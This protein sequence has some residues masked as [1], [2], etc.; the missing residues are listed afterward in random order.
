[1]QKV[2]VIGAGLSGVV[3]ARHLGSRADVTVFEKS[4][5]P[6]GR[7]STRRNAGFEFD[8]GAQFFTARDPRF[9]LFL[10]PYLRSGLV[11]DWSPRLLT[12]SRDAKPYKRDWF[13]PHYVAVPGMNALV[14]ELAKDVTV[15]VGEEI[16]QT[17]FHD[18]LWYP[19]GGSGEV[20]GPF[21]W[22]VSTCPVEQTR[23]LLPEDFQQ[24]TESVKLQGCFALMLGF[25]RQ[26]KTN[27]QA[28]VFK[29]SCLDWAAWN[30]SKPGR[31]G[32][33]SLTVLSDNAWAEEHLED[34][35]EVVQ[36]RMLEE[37]LEVAG[38]AVGDAAVQLHR[39][40]YAN[41]S[42]PLGESFLIDPER[43]VAACGDWC[44]GNR[45]EAAFLSAARLANRM[46]QLIP[47]TGESRAAGR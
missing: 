45:V 28:A 36:T 35:L 37:L 10:E 25:E 41:V 5:G 27:W 2:A 39:W 22:L 23:T 6:G 9:Q 40:R 26:P 3:L 17:G 7:L 32:R 11:Q 34:P 38:I 8:H 12:L 4:R 18:G 47:P 13:E 19:R 1:M 20:H 43:R 46:F 14:K 16:V 42:T 44:L 30:G 31:S 21:D 15:R 33:A 29:E 24:A